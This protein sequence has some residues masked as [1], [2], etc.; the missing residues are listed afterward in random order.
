[1]GLKMSNPLLRF[2][3]FK[4]RLLTSPWRAKPD[5][6]IAGTEK[7]GT[8]HLFDSLSR[9]RQ[10]IPSM[11]KELEYFPTSKRTLERL[12]YQQY[13]PL[14]PTL[15]SLARTHEN[16]RALTGEAS[17]NYMF[18][19]RAVQQ[20]ADLIPDA[21]IIVM[22]RNPI[23][24]AYSKYS[25]VI[26]GNHSAVEKLSFHDAV[27]LEL[28]EISNRGGPNS[29][30]HWMNERNYISRGLYASQLTEIYKAFDRSQVLVIDSHQYN[31]EFDKTYSHILAFLGL[32]NDRGATLRKIATS[33]GPKLDE[34]TRLLLSDFFKEPNQQL[35]ELLSR[36]FCW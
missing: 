30:D 32:T 21:K 29:K 13:F 6:I 16:Q 8:S 35:E 7:G 18:D 15:R 23:L 19:P 5:F 4:L 22:L 34:H 28:E 11:F 36:K 2:M 26:R 14:R 20:L 24:R 31:T 17:P 3:R 25:H 1:M 27:I 33:N 10:I 12:R 9:H